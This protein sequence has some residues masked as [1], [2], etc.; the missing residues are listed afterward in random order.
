MN[1][2]QVQGDTLTRNNKSKHPFRHK[3][4]WV[5]SVLGTV[6]I[7]YNRA[8]HLNAVEP[9]SYLPSRYESLQNVNSWWPVLFLVTREVWAVQSKQMGYLE[10]KGGWSLLLY[11]PRNLE[12]LETFLACDRLLSLFSKN[13][14]Q[15]SSMIT[16]QVY[17][18]A[19]GWRIWSLKISLQLYIEGESM[20][21]GMWYHKE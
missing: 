9:R 8:V 21:E 5:W 17:L 20:A 11:L 15:V 13:D 18:G 10:E 4:L 2:I 7:T 3:P 6:K 12:W 1:C 19:E 16:I 14:N